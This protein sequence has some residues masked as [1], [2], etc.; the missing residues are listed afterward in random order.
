ML[1]SGGV[2]EGKTTTLLNLAVTISHSGERVLMVESDLRR[3]S[4][5]RL[6]EIDQPD[7]GIATVLSNK[8]SYSDVI[9][10]TEIKNPNTALAQQVVEN[11]KQRFIL[12]GTDGPD[13]NVIILK[14]PLC[15]SMD[16]ANEFLRSFKESLVQAPS[17]Q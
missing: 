2:G 8:M 15:F 5:Y 3:P 10:D 12:A 11:L 13:N 14:P 16:N 6:L 9:M 17:H 7:K 4:I 1:T